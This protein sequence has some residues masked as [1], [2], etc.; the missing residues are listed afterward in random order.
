V[1]VVSEFGVRFA[2]SA[3]PMT[4]RP[5]P[6]A[7]DAPDVADGDLIGKSRGGDLDA[8]SRLV[9]RYQDSVFRVALS[10][11]GDRHDAEEAA[12]EAFIRAFRA[13]DRFRD[14]LP[15]RPWLLKIVLNEARGRRRARARSF[16]LA[17]R[18]ESR[19]REAFDP[20]PLDQVL[21]DE[22]DDVLG[23][24]ISRLRVDHRRVIFARYVLDL[25]EAETALLLGCPRGTVK[26]RLS[27]A[28]AQLRQIIDTDAAR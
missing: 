3:D 28:I 24:A 7:R 13:L 27:R 8:F 23:A 2:P 19:H 21:I 1:V 9:L 10:V 15:F 6:G 14:D 22:R 11:T 16:R 26:S 18:A 4:T 12:Q 5:V 25:D 17:L 20:D